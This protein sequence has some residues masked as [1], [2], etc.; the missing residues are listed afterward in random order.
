MDKWLEVSPSYMELHDAQL[1]SCTTM[2]LIESVIG[3]F[4]EKKFLILS[5]VNIICTEA[6]YN[7]RK[8]T[9]CVSCVMSDVW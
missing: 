3:F 1:N 4:N 2:D 5:D 6:F 8:S 7:V 9:L